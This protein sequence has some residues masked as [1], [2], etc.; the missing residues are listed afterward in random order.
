M[1]TSHSLYENL[2]RTPDVRQVVYRQLF[3]NEVP[4]K[5]LEE[6]RNATNK[7]WVLGSDHFKRRIEKQ[8][9]RQVAPV[10]KGGD[11]KS[12]HFQRKNKINRV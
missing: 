8:L 11:R 9:S 1:I 10:N 5:T 4:E 6:I 12:E 3:K 2:G 7:A